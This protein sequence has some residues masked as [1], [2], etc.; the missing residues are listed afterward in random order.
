MSP[1]SGVDMLL[2]RG[3]YEVDVLAR[4][5]LD[6]VHEFV[7]KAITLQAWPFDMFLTHR[8]Y[9]HHRRFMSKTSIVAPELL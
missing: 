8:V 5:M 4:R 2:L 3:V 1:V 6:R 7:L 9:I